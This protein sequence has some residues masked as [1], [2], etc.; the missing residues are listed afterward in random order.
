MFCYHLLSV[1][2]FL[3]S[4]SGAIF[5]G[6]P[7]RKLYVIGVTGTKGKS[8]TIEVI[9]AI[10]EEAGYKTALNS[11]VRQ[12]IG[13]NSVKNSSNNSMQGRWHIQHFL[14]KAAREKCQ[15]A[16]IEVTS[17]GVLQHRDKFILWDAAVFLNITP[18]HIEAHGSFESYRNAKVSFF[19]HASNSSK[20]NKVFVLNRDDENS[21]FFEEVINTK[22]GDVV[23]SFSLK[24]ALRGSK[25]IA[26]EAL[27]NADLTT[28]EAR[29][30]ISDWLMPDFNL[31]N[32]LAA[33]VLAREIKIKGEI[34]LSALKKFQGIPGRMEYV[35]R[36]PFK[37]IV[38][39]AHTPDSLEKAYKTLKTDLSGTDGRLI[40][41][42]GSCGGSRDVWKRPVMGKLAG[43][44]CDK[45]YLTNEDP[46][47]EDP[48]SIIMDIKTGVRR[49]AVSLEVEL[50]RGEAIRKAISE[51]SKNDTVIITG[52]GSEVWLHEAHG[53]RLPW[54]DKEKALLALQAAR[55][56]S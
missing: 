27:N 31:E 36:E 8:S 24:D 15:F 47:D 35:K 23:T 26:K 52:K 46:Y 14:W 16:I 22:T 7:S 10:L 51:A 49:S 17:Q 55:T 53:K 6:L 42:L 50:D 39:Y 28:K 1:Y 41:V 32:A 3:W 48:K 20:N 18:E 33:I 34:M 30:K 43:E 45:I 54:S 2:H 56:D 13:T 44:Y 38:D 19:K 40:C 11:S 4:L 29:A 12:K 25:D 37:V 9:S 5:F 21:R